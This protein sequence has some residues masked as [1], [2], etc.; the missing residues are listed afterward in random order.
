M[1]NDSAGET[2]KIIKNNFSIAIFA[3]VILSI[4]P[5]VIEYWKHKKAGR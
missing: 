4:L 1:K 3:V 2:K 5:I